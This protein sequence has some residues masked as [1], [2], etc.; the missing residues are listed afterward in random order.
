[1]PA[2]HMCGCCRVRS[3]THVLSARA[4]CRNT[5]APVPAVS[6]VAHYLVGLPGQPVR[7]QGT[8]WMYHPTRPARSTWSEPDALLPVRAGEPACAPAAPPSRT[9]PLLPQSTDSGA[10]IGTERFRAGRR[11]VCDTQLLTLPLRGSVNA[12]APPP[13]LPMLPSDRA[14]SSAPADAATTVSS[15]HAHPGAAATVALCAAR[16]SRASRQILH[17]LLALRGSRSA[18]RAATGCCANSPPPPT[19]RSP[20]QPPCI[21]API[22]R[23]HG[24]ASMI[25]RPA[26][27]TLCGARFRP[28]CPRCHRAPAA[29]PRRSPLPAS[30]PT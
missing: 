20:R 18:C 4:P 24:C 26:A 28:R 8:L 13:Q 9:C 7:G 16:G 10:R 1:M 30:R 12:G 27:A 22:S 19:R 23:H 5:W 2:P 21:P 17:G 3:L 14:P 29:P 6:Y 11:G 15:C 25:S